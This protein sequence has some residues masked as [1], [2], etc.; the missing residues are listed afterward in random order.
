MKLTDE[1]I[2][3]ALGEAKSDIFDRKADV[4]IGEALTRRELFREIEAIE[5]RDPKRF[6]NSVLVEIVEADLSVCH[7]RDRQVASHVLNQLV[8][9]LSAHFKREANATCSGKL[10]LDQILEVLDS[11]T[12]GNPSAEP[13]PVFADAATAQA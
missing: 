10:S 1:M 13:P 6:P 5:E 8:V 12:C 3:G 11:V 2:C 7:E 9:V 4:R